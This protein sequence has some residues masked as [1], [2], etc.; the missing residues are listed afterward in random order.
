MPSFL[1]PGW[2]KSGPAQPFAL[3]FILEVI[4]SSIVRYWY[5]GFRFT[6]SRLGCF[7]TH[8]KQPQDVCDRTL[9]VYIYICV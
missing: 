3:G 5:L 6:I 4:E 1:R 7:P 9:Y 8:V 2:L